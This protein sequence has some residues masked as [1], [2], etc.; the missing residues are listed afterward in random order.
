MPQELATTFETTD[1]PQVDEIQSEFESKTTT[2]TYQ[3]SNGGFGR[4]GGFIFEVSPNLN[5]SILIRNLKND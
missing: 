2:M 5:L 3:Y 1:L 4:N